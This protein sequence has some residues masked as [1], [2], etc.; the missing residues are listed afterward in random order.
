MNGQKI[1]LVQMD[2]KF[3]PKLTGRERQGAD[4]REERGGAVPRAARRPRRPSSRC[5]SSTRCPLIAPSTGAMVLQSRCTLGFNVRATYQREAERAGAAPSLIGI[6][7]HR[8][9][10]RRRQLRR[11]PARGRQEGLRGGGQ[12]PG[13]RREATARS[14]GTSAKIRRLVASSDGRPLLFMGSGNA[15]WSTASP[16]S[17]KAGSRA[18]RHLLEQRLRRFISGAQGERARDRHAGVPYERSLAAPIV[19][20]TTAVARAWRGV[21]PAMLK[22][23]PP[24][25]CG[26]RPQARRRQPSHEDPA[27]TGVDEQGRHRRAGVSF[28]PTDHTTWSSSTCPSSEQDGKVPSRSPGP[29]PIRPRAVESAPARRPPR[30]A[31]RNAILCAGDATTCIS[32]RARGQSAA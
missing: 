19:E 24:P 31:S 10:P 4:H 17:W 20:G 14:P 9:H 16:P 2:D 32:R 5:S 15:A 22:A 8:R 25:R 1:E 7:A 21:T 12:E 13:V 29:L 30:A 11:R 6:R 23:T 26:D 27:G 3:D 18:D 28:S